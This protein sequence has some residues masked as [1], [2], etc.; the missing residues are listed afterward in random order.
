MGGSG[1][2]AGAESIDENRKGALPS[3]ML[4]VFGCLKLWS[5]W[6]KAQARCSL[7][8]T[9]TGAA[10]KE[11]IVKDHYKSGRSGIYNEMRAWYNALQCL[12]VQD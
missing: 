9:R 11:M 5:S 6:R 8:L 3:D 7:T 1:T 12:T 10:L 2:A 4:I